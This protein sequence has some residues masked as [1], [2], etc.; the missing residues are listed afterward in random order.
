M[1][2]FVRV[3]ITGKAYGPFPSRSE[4]ETWLVSEGYALTYEDVTFR[5]YECESVGW[6]VVRA[7]NG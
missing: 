7:V 3:G 6:S 1:T 2:C 5:V 4:V